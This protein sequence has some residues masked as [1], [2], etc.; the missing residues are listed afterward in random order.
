MT[1]ITILFFFRKLDFLGVSQQ[2]IKMILI[3]FSFVFKFRKPLTKLMISVKK[4]KREFENIQIIQIK[5][6]FCVNG[7]RV[8]DTK[9]YKNEFFVP[10]EKELEK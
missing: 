5:S 7:E 4:K 3:P 1:E 9:I 6:N 10:M 2:Q 8:G